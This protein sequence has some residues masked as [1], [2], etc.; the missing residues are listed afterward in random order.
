MGIVKISTII[1]KVYK[2]RKAMAFTGNRFI[3]Q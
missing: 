1:N 2:K 3:T